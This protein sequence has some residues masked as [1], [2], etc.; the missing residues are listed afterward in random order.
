MPPVPEEAPFVL[1]ILAINHNCGSAPVSGQP[2]QAANGFRACSCGSAF[3]LD[4]IF[5][6]AFESVNVSSPS[7]S[8]ALA[9]VL[10]SFVLKVA[11]NLSFRDPAFSVK[12][13]HSN[14]LW[15]LLL[16]LKG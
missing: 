3:D 8:R 14:Q 12:V 5:L 11:C 2:L 16:K 13:Y 15:L 10:E 7:A 6:A 4:V 1:A 9:D